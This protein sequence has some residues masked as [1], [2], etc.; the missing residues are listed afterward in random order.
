MLFVVLALAIHAVLL[1]GVQFGISF[2]PAPRLADT[3]DVVLVRWRSE[4]RAG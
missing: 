1:I 4:K 2:N 3:L